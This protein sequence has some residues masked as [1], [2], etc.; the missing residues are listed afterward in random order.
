MAEMFDHDAIDFKTVIV[1][2]SNVMDWMTD[3]ILRLCWRSNLL[4]PAVWSNEVQ[5]KFEEK[6]KSAHE[7][8]DALADNL[9]PV[10]MLID[11]P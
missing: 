6:N 5:L 8:R 3:W 11:H 2:Y 1:L 4:L 10:M 7:W 9:Q